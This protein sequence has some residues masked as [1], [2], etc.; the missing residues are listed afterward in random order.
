LG[1]MLMQALEN[2]GFVKFPK[3]GDVKEDDSGEA[4]AQG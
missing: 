3:A 4:T 1:E 2:S